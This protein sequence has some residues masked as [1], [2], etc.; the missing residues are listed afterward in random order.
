VSAVR[1]VV[2]D[3]LVG[4]VSQQRRRQDVSEDQRLVVDDQVS[5]S[6]GSGGESGLMPAGRP[7]SW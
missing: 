3:Q 7:N 4:L 6:R 5:R 2:V 1:A